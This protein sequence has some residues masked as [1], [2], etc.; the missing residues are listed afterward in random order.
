MT[1]DGTLA[2]RNMEKKD[3]GVYGCL[4]SNQAGTDTMTSILTYIGECT[5]IPPLAVL[6][7]AIEGYGVGVGGCLTACSTIHIALYIIFICCLLFNN[8]LSQESPVVT[9][10][11]SDI[12]IGIGETTVMACSAS[13]TPQPEIWW[14]KG[15]NFGEVEKGGKLDKLIIKY[16]LKLTII[17]VRAFFM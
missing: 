1:S 10:A 9:V 4:A 17:L 8:S 3:G 15:N 5:S 13:G 6:T 14:Y 2:I 11:L 7:S 12:L 16:I